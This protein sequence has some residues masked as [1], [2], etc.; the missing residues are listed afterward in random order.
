MDVYL[1][2]DQGNIYNVYASHWGWTAPMTRLIRRV[3]PPLVV[4][5][6]PKTR[7]M[8]TN[9]LGMALQESNTKE[10]ICTNIDIQYK[11]I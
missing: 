1:D 4:T 5:L 2:T 8:I 9:R 7:A 10:T 6:C 11:K 3:L